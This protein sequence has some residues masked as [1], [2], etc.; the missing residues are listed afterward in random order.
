MT[1]VGVT[2]DARVA[3]L[4]QPGVVD[5]DIVDDKVLSICELG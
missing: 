1:D 2:G 5:S 4:A 3:G